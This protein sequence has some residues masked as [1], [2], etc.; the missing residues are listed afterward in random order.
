MRDKEEDPFAVFGDDDDD[1]DDEPQVVDQEATR[2]AQSL[3]DRANHSPTRQ[4]TSQPKQSDNVPQQGD[5]IPLPEK[6]RQLQTFSK[7]PEP[8]YRGPFLVVVTA[9]VGGRECIAAQDLPPGTL[10][11]VEEPVVAWTLPP[12]SDVE[13][14]CFLQSLLQ[15]NEER[16]VLDLLQDLH[17]TR[18]A[19][20]QSAD[21]DQQIGAMMNGLLE[22]KETN[23]LI[24]QCWQEYSQK[25]DCELTKR[26]LL[27]LVL[28]IRYN[29]LQSG[30]FL[31][32]AM[33]NHASAP[34]C[35]KFRPS[36]QQQHPYSEV[37]TTRHVPSGHALTISYLPQLVAL[38]SRRVSLWNQHR[39]D[40]IRDSGVETD[41]P[42]HQ[43]MEMVQGTLV[44]GDCNRVDP[45]SVTYRIE[46]AAA[47]LQDLMLGE[48][49]S[50]AASELA[51]LELCTAAEQQLQNGQHVLLLRCR[52]IH[53][54]FCDLVQRD[55]DDLR[56]PQRAQLLGRL[57]VTARKLAV[58]Q[59]MWYGSDHF[60]L[61]QTYLELS[62]A[63][64][65]LLAKS[66][67]HLVALG[68]DGLDNATAWAKLEHS[69]LSEYQR[70]KA[71]YP[72][73]AEERIKEAQEAAA[74]AAESKE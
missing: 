63:I 26:D 6:Q 21:D 65:E 22:N 29:G 46:Q 31:Y 28:V 15:Q 54:E 27:R 41:G 24:E 47:A 9:A 11:L 3:L 10:L 2:M 23:D 69:S 35:V 60:D 36:Q 32:A 52:K 14:I 16:N 57:I 38:A 13:I 56:A 12:E 20:E 73:D 7:W 72:Y 48:P 1:D 17:P 18:L 4:T 70:I 49:P 71:L 51:A 55:E 30:L 45:D 40:I 59:T 19:V 25:P 62:Q 58:L 42:Q 64:D 44:V 53:L 66:P 67:K 68:M 34:N 74:A 50:H 37:R 5:K 61:A 39:F 33:W 8:L 43:A